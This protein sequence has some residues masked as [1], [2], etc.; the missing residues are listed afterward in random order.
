MLSRVADRLYWGARYLERAENT[1][2]LVRVYDGLMLDLPPEAGIAWPVLLDIVGGR[3]LFRTLHPKATDRATIRFLLADP[4]NPSSVLSSLEQARENFRTTRDLAPSEAWR[5]VNEMYLDSRKRLPRAVSQRGRNE[6]LRDVIEG[7]QQLRGLMA[8]TMSHGEAYQFIR[9]GRNI[10]RA[11]MTTRIIDSAATMLL[12]R[13]E[14]VQRFDN[15]L[16]MAVLKSLSGYQMYRQSVRRRIH[17]TDAVA[18]LLKDLHFPRSFARCLHQIE[19][20]I[21]DLPR[22]AD[23]TRA[24]ARLRRIVGERA[25]GPE[26]VSVLHDFLDELQVELGA[27]HAQIAATWFLPDMTS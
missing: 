21:D 15:T 27:V 19:S 14:N 20:G 18:F 4:D 17:G 10:E 1:S 24:V 8:D 2:R 3:E 6:A 9:I 22:N 16:W 11:D 13:H 5:C 7:V 23:A 12:S 26:D 25:M